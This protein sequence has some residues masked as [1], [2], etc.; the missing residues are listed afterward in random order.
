MFGRKKRAAAEAST[1][2]APL[3]AGTSTGPTISLTELTEEWALELANMRA[4]VTSCVAEND[5]P[6]DLRHPTSDGCS[7]PRPHTCVS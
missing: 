1:T 2:G 5:P 3:A 6:L 7:A 4:W